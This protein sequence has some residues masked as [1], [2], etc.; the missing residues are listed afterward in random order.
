MISDILS[1]TF[2]IKQFIVLVLAIL[3]ILP[4]HEFAHAYVAKLLGDNTAKN[5]GRLTLNP[6]AHLDMYG[7][8]MMLLVGVGF[9]K[10]VPINPNNFKKPKV[11]MAISSLAGPVSNF[12]LTFVLIILH[13]VLFWSSF[14]MDPNVLYEMVYNGQSSAATVIYDIS[15]LVFNLAFISA[16]LG[17]FNLIPIPPLDGSRIATMFLPEKLYFKIMQYEQYIMFAFILLVILDNRGS[18]VVG[19]VI[20]YGGEMI[21]DFFNNIT[22]FIDKLFVTMGGL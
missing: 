16:V 21:C 19:N 9:A 6:L 22:A 18:G 10:G 15:Y 2:D 4:L 7:T 14:L 12:L 8:I 17:I 3:I 1:G 13:K 5:M 20:S 11:G